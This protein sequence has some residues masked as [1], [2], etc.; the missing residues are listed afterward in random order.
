LLLTFSP[1]LV[2]V[3]PISWYSQGFGEIMPEI[4]RVTRCKSEAIAQML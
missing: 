1:A 3:P 2:L 4:L